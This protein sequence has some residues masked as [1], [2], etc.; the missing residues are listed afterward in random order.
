MNKAK[1]VVSLDF[2]LHW[3]G[4]EKWDPD[5]LH[6]Y[7]VN[8]RDIVIPGILE[9]FDK[10]EIHATWATVGLLFHSNKSDLES[11]LPKLRP[12]YQAAELSAYNYMDR[13]PLGESESKDLL[14]YGASLIKLITTYPHQEIGTHTFSHYFCNEPGQTLE[15]FNA[16]LESARKS[17]SSLGVNL[18]SLVFPRNQFNSDYLKICA[19]QGIRVVRTNPKDWFWDIQSTERESYWL[20]LNRGLDAYISIGKKN[21]YKVDE[22]LKTQG[23]LQLP[24]SRLLRPWSPKFPLLNSL[25]ISRIISEMRLSALN[26]EIYHLW[27]HPHNFGKYPTQNL[28]DLEKILLNYSKLRSSLAMTSMNFSEITQKYF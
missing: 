7:F 6:R 3:G 19:D 24:A 26:G 28:R 25:R 10:Y 17:A 13:N 8:T 4:F 20:R 5:L 15:Q 1:L 16:D 12:T 14:H 23:V 2:E 18:E 21:S 22:F 9:L 27:W 11:N